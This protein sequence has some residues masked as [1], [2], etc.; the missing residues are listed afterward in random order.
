MCGKGTLIWQNG[1]QYEG[2]FKNNKMNG[3]GKLTN[4][5]GSISEGFFENGKKQGLFVEIC[6][7]KKKK[8]I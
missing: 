1:V 8:N 2:F 7:E 3:N 6:K 4:L 5:D